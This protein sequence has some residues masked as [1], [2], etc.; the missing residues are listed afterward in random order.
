MDNAL[1]KIELQCHIWQTPSD[2]RDPLFIL[3]FSHGSQS[4]LYGSSAPSGSHVI[5]TLGRRDTL[6]AKGFVFQLNKSGFT[7]AHPTRSLTT[8]SDC[9]VGVDKIVGYMMCT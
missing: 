1:V 2:M 7:L 5:R 6:K 3:C 4:S 9:T 8:R